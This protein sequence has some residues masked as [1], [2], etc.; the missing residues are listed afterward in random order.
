MAAM[1]SYRGNA[2]IQQF[3]CEIFSI[4]AFYSSSGRQITVLAGVVTYIL[5]AMDAHQANE[6]IQHIASVTIR[7]LSC[8]ISLFE[9]NLVTARVIEAAHKTLH[10]HQASFPILVNLCIALTLMACT[11]TV[12]CASIIS[13]GGLLLMMFGSIITRLPSNTVMHAR[14]LTLLV[15]LRSLY[16][17]YYMQGPRRRAVGVQ[18]P[19]EVRNGSAI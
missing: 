9:S 3:G 14:G 12:S 15:T 5:G 7:I 6:S 11:S 16:D 10:L 4:L 18:P 13:D 19:E 8:H 17:L 1:N 2:C